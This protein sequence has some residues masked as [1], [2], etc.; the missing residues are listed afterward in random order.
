MGE[1][2]KVP[3]IR[4]CAG[5]HDRNETPV[6][7]E[8]PLASL[9]GSIRER[10]RGEG[11]VAGCL[12]REDESTEISCQIESAGDSSALVRFLLPTLLAG[13][14]EVF[15]LVADGA[16]GASADLGVGVV[17]D[18]T[19]DR[20]L[21][22]GE[23][24]TS[25]VF[26][27]TYAKPYIGPVVGPYGHHVTRLDMEIKEHPHHRSMW[28]AIGDVN[29]VDCWNEPQGVYGKQSVQGSVSR[30]SGPVSLSIGA[31][32]LWTDFN[33]KELLKERRVLTFR[34]TPPS[35]R[36]IDVYSKF[37][38]DSLDVT[39]GPTK[40]AG[41]LGIRVATSMQVTNGGTIE[42]SLGARSEAECW[43]KRAFWC[44]YS[45]MVEGHRVGISIFDHPLNMEYPT[46]WHVRDYGLMAPNNLFFKGPVSLNMGESLDYRYRIYIHV[47]DAEY[48]SVNKKFLDYAIP[49]TYQVLQP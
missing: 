22:D 37:T 32:I 15:F 35:S 9:N 39:F 20:V 17:S 36:F 11:T 41:P 45:G 40:E 27:E 42:N 31:N 21:I 44:D 49:P 38:A 14:E 34:R 5:L 29:G 26:D 48:G 33:G 47:G 16:E 12:L 8:V 28:V 3:R 10:L 43:G 2:E 19:E 7:M 46:H 23:Y 24:F 18:E 30:S 6:D 25:C 1:K 13:E 4:V